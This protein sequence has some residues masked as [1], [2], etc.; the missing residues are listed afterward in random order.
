MLLSSSHCPLVTVNTEDKNKFIKRT[1]AF[2]QPTFLHTLNLPILI[3]GSH[4]CKPF[5]ITSV[6]LKIKLKITKIFTNRVS[7][8]H[9]FLSCWVC[10]FSSYSFL[11][12]LSPQY[13][14]LNSS[15]PI[16]CH[17][18]ILD[19]MPR[20]LTD[21]HLHVSDTCFSNPSYVKSMWLN[22]TLAI[23]HSVINPCVNFSGLI[24]C[25]L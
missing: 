2:V 8:L 15:I 10:V 24:S 17:G 16:N 6:L 25:V 20:R 5:S 11:P 23:I 19:P 1:E 4:G 7:F 21:S 12:R 3:W 13:P 22:C 9:L 18:L 14:L